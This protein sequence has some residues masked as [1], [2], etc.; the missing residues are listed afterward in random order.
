M[1][2]THFKLFKALKSRSPMRA[3]IIILLSVS[4]N[5][6]STCEQIN[7]TKKIRIATL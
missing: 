7:D 2:E 4:F 6:F 5:S 1:Y 3:N